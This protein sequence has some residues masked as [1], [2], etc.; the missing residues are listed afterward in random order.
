MCKSCT[1]PPDIS[2]DQNYAQC[3]QRS[4]CLSGC[5][6]AVARCILRHAGSAARS[7]PGA[8]G[9]PARS[10]LAPHFL[11]DF[12]QGLRGPWQHVVEPGGRRRAL[13]DPQQRGG[14]AGRGQGAGRWVIAAPRA[15]GA[16]TQTPPQHSQAPAPRRPWV[17]G[18]G[19]APAGGLPGA[20][21]EERRVHTR[22]LHRRPPAARRRAAAV[23]AAGER[24][25][26]AALWEE[27]HAVWA[28]RS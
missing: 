13:G 8:R 20:R 9:A 22:R 12:I 7:Q 14:R 15:H 27:T 25:C 24:L 6:L 4:V 5:R 21:Q 1:V 23:A 16:A 3:L 17:R 18:A 2:V 11:C 10:L 28:A 26:C 19:Q